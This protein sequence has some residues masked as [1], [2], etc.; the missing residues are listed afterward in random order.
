MNAV[1]REEYEVPVISN[2]AIEAQLIN[3]RDSIQDVRASQSV[4]QARADKTN[5]RMEVINTTLSAKIDA[6][7]ARLSDKIDKTNDRIDAVDA[8]LSGKIDKT[9]DRIE[10]VRTSLGEK[11]DAF[12]GEILA[13]FDKQSEQILALGK[14]VDWVHISVKVVLAILG[15]CVSAAVIVN[16]LR[17]LRWI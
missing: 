17:T 6:V 8:R 14:G 3:L 12:K 16:T 9:N 5:D 4:L 10:A 15:L 7:D 1:F 13:R 2:E 11:M